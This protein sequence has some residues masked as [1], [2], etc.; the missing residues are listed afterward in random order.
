MVY[1]A[2]A[3]TYCYGPNLNKHNGEKSWK[4]WNNNIP[5]L[6]QSM[7]RKGTIVLGAEMDKLQ[8]TTHKTGS[9]TNCT[10]I[11]LIHNGQCPLEPNNACQQHQRHHFCSRDKCAG[12]V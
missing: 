7:H 3:T 11:H 6:E 2:N 1:D 9:T 8:K 4:K 10:V 5:L 12:L